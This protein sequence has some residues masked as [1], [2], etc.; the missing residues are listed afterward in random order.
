MRTTVN[1]ITEEGTLLTG[2]DYKNQAWVVKGRYVRCGHPEI[3][4]CLC[5]GTLHEGEICRERGDGWED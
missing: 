4:D 3:M 2:Y 1:Q 5:Y